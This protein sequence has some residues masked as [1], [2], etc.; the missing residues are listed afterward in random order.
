MA[1]AVLRIRCAAYNGTFHTVFRHYMKARVAS[2][3]GP[4]KRQD[5]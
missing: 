5:E 4:E 1:N 2:V 3:H